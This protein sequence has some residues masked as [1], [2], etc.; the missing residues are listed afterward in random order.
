VSYIWQEEVID[1]FEPEEV[2]LKFKPITCQQFKAILELRRKELLKDDILGGRFIEHTE[3]CPRCARDYDKFFE[4]D[5]Q[6]LIDKAVNFLA[7]LDD[8]KKS[9]H[10]IWCFRKETLKEYVEGQLTPYETSMIEDHLLLDK[11]P[12]CSE[13]VKELRQKQKNHKISGTT[14]THHCNSGCSLSRMYLYSS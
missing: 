14:V 13:Y 11:C 3:V 6:R 8:I 4:N 12:D 10:Y 7:N 5:Y 9:W 1:V 2:K